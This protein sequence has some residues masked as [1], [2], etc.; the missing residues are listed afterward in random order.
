MSGV[1]LV[2][3]VGPVDHD[4]VAHVCLTIGQQFPRAWCT[5]DA[6]P[7][8]GDAYDPRRGQYSADEILYSLDPGGSERVLGLVDA[9][10]FVPDLNFVFGLAQMGG[11][12]AVIALPR[13]REE[14][15]G[16]PPDT[17]LLLER[18]AKEAVHE[19]GHTFGL[20]HCD[21]PCCVMAFSNRLE[22]TDANDAAFCDSHRAQIG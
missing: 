16:C 12:R 14:F 1:I 10:L 15:W 17:G 19:L 7:L 13:L 20:H 11:R 4:I 2:V 8:P 6:R 9:D 22:D 21:D 3:P 5:G 18:V